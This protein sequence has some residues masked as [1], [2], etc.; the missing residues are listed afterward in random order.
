MNKV[1]LMLAI[2]LPSLTAQSA[3]AEATGFVAPDCKVEIEK[4]CADKE[5]GR[6][7][8]R[9]C[10]EAKKGELSEACQKALD[11]T[12]PGKGRGKKRRQ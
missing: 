7:E 11:S 6:G 8:V 1:I 12:G 10:L 9:A 2:V 5:H 4:F 3:F